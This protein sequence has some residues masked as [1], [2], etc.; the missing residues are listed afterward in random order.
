MNDLSRIYLYID[1]SGTPYLN[2]DRSSF[3]VLV[4]VL[5]G[6]YSN[7]HPIYYL[8]EI[9]RKYGIEY[10][11]NFHAVDIFEKIIDKNG[12]THPSYINS[13]KIA[14]ALIYEISSFIENFPLH[15]DAYLIRKGSFLR[16][17][18]LSKTAIK[19]SRCSK[20]IKK[21]VCFLP[22]SYAITRLAFNFAQ[23]KRLV[24]SDRV[25]TITFESRA[26]NELI[27]SVLE[28]IS[29]GENFIYEKSKEKAKTF[30]ENVVSFQFAKKGACL[31]GL[32]LA[33]IIGFALHQRYA[34]RVGKFRGRGLARL[35]KSIDKKS[36]IGRNQL[37]ISKNL[38]KY[39]T[40]A[41]LDKTTKIRT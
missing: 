36:S 11:Q 41:A 29:H 13:D 7:G 12:N 32:A 4:G 26:E 8:D 33:D 6:G 18:S 19:N 40:K 39:L 17:L 5:T 22:Y 25:G 14:K 15:I 9:F 10:T 27:V 30:N 3:F 35:L 31:P 38:K 16:A 34:R 28:Q 1:E 21:E 24:N 37:R 23:H 20:F 2:D